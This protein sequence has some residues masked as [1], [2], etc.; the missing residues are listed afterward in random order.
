MRIPLPD[1]EVMNLEVGGE[2]WE[3]FVRWLYFSNVHPIAGIMYDY[4]SVDNIKFQ[5]AMEGYGKGYMIKEG[6]YL[7]PNPHS[8]FPC[9]MRPEQARRYMAAGPG[10]F[11]G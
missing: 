2:K 7:Y 6:I 11:G 3:A 1:R 5:R 10:E 9:S 8:I 4:T